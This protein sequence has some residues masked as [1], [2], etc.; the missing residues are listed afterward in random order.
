TDTAGGLLDRIRREIATEEELLLAPEFFLALADH[1]PDI[2]GVDIQLERGHPDTEMTRHRYDVIVYKAP[3]RARSMH[4]VPTRAWHDLPDTTA[5]RA[6]LEHER[7]DALRVTGIPHAGVIDEVAAHQA[8]GHAHPDTPL[9]DIVD[10]VSDGADILDPHT[11]RSAPVPEDLHRI[12]DET[13]YTTAVTYSTTPGHLDAIFHTPTTQH[14]PLTDLYRPADQV[15]PLSRYVNDPAAAHRTTQLRA[16]VAGRLPEY[17]VPAAIVILDSLPVTANGKLDRTALPAPDFGLGRYRAPRTP[18]EHTLTDLYAEILGVPRVGIDDSFFDL[19]GHSLLATRLISRIRTTLG[20]ELPIRVLF[21]APTIAELSTRLDNTRPIRP[22]L[23]PVERPDGIPLS[24]AQQRLWFLHQYEGPSA[25]Y[26]IPLALRLT[27]PLNT[28]ALTAA[29]DDVIARHEPL[30]TLFGAI[31]GQPFQHILPP[32][33]ATTS[34]EVTDLDTHQLDDAVAAAAGYR[35][36]L[37]TEIP[38]RATILRCRPDEHVLVLLVHHIAGDGWSLAPLIEDLTHAYTARRD[39]EEPHWQPLPVQYADY[40]LWQH[41]LLGEITDPDSALSTQYRYWEHELGGAPDLTPLPTD[42]P[43]PKTA[44]YHGD[45]IDFTIPAHL[46]HR[47]DQLARHHGVTMSMLTQS[48][49]A[50][51]L[52]KLGAGTDLT[53]GSPIAGRTD[54]ALTD[55]IGFFVNTWVLRVDLAH[56]PRFDQVLDQVRDKALASY[57]HQDLPFELLVELLNP[58][59]TTAYHPLFQV[60]LAWQNNTLPDIDLPDLQA[61]ALP[62]PTGTAKFDLFIN[63]VDPGDPDQD[64][65]ALIEYATDLFDPHTVRALTHRYLT[66][67]DTIATNPHTRLS[68]IEILN[69]DERHTILETWNHTHTHTLIP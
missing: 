63:L 26:N 14:T 65:P 58:T 47:L 33:H 22:P 38:L 56:H 20:V 30:R 1:H 69:P 42:R 53:I 62:A 31:E 8:A 27:G 55:L 15:G 19:G 5:L 64:I 28:N 68:D 43:R 18:D 21:D 37:A 50:V 4:T 46:H 34:I 16:Y 3:T 54:T 7:P 24:H 17:M 23:L 9:T 10:N 45:T 6:L 12:G 32:D 29:L 2:T 41:H 11:D 39:G 59:R 49:L 36:D 52:H 61:T 25:T 66:V 48:A 44:S 51:L 40:T 13:G 60:C 57:D 35:F 67:L